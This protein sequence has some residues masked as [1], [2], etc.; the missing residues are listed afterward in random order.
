MTD[1]CDAERSALRAVWPASAQYLCIFHILQQVWRWLLDTR[2]GVPKEDRQGLMAATKQLVYAPSPEAFELILG[3]LDLPHDGFARLD[4]FYCYERMD[5]D[6]I[7]M[8]RLLRY[9]PW[10][11][12]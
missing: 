7:S 5:F 6:Y 8:P 9:V 4:P 10:F 1:N 3:G 12:R 11:A 2:H